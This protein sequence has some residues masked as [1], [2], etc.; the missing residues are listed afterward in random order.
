M[1]AAPGIQ[2]DDNTHRKAVVDRIGELQ[3]KMK[4]EAA[5]LQPLIEERGKLQAEVLGWYEDYDPERSDA[6]EAD[7]YLLKVTPRE[8]EREITD[9]PKC[10]RLLR[11]TIA[12]FLKVCTIP[13][14]LVDKRIPEEKHGL[15]LVK[16]RTGPRDITVMRKPQPPPAA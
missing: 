14:K 8:N 2:V 12:E 5:R 7:R 16:K 4:F 9:R 3:E 13:L 11:M 6:W 10:Y 15:F 1:G